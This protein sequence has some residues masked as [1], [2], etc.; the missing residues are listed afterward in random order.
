VG[1]INERLINY[2]KRMFFNQWRLV[3]VEPDDALLGKGSFG[4]V[5]AVYRDERDKDGQMNRYLAAIKLISIDP[6]NIRMPRSRTREQQQN[7]LREELR[8]VQKEIDIMKRLEGEANI[9]YFK[10]SQVIRRPDMDLECWDVLICM[11]RL[12]VLRQHLRD[13]ELV[14]GTD[15][16]L[17]EILYI[18]KEISTA[19]KI[20]EKK[21]I[22]HTDVKPE[23]I[24]YAPG[25]GR[26]KLSDF[27][28]SIDGTSFKSGIRYGTSDYMSPEMYNRK[29]GD[30]RT[31]MYSL[32]VMIY[33][34]LNGNQLPLQLG[35]D[36][37]L[38]WK[39]RLVDLRP[40]QP[41][42]KIPEDVNEVLM[43]C[44]EIDPQKRYANCSELADVVDALYVKHQAAKRVSDARKKVIPIA[45]GVIAGA[46][47]L[48]GMLV[49]GTGKAEGIRHMPAEAENV[50][51][52]QQTAE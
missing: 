7:I 2:N 19:L 50:C 12:V 24:F 1:D 14:P 49:S 21:H 22:L 40:V 37:E 33:E 8:F 51:L 44:L 36:R 4:R 47:L 26:Y 20:C 45:L 15:E 18:W 46:M 27:G 38:A 42:K 6:Q 43:R 29:G 41:L 9:A 35:I 17:M 25:P 3:G 13:L 28:T 16:Y 39:E 52:W 23:N 11:E 10:N 31:D 34:L 48:I 32:A 5:Y 30:S